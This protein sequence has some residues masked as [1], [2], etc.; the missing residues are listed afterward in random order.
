MT[1]SRGRAGTTLAIFMGLALGLSA[2]AKGQDGAA[3]ADPVAPPAPDAAPAPLDPRIEELRR[4]VQALR[5]EVEA[6]GEEKDKK[7]KLTG[8]QFQLRGGWFNLAHNHRTDILS[9]DDHQHG[10][11]VGIGLVVPIMP[12]LGP[13][14]LL[15]NLAIE[16]RQVA[17]STV[18]RSVLTN[19]SGTLSY[20]NIVACPMVRFKLSETIRP[21]VLA[22]LNM[23]VATPPTDAVTYLDLGVT[24]GLG[25]DFKVHERVSVGFDYRYS[26]F[27][28]SDQENEDYG[29]L[30]GYVG[31]NF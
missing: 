27:G 15:A 1:G 9:G 18:Y 24:I 20:L 14:D 13:I 25:L 2:T 17:Y 29:L 7:G 10:W 31:F 3:P 26:W 30:S 23:Q 28:V 16:Y 6:K 12:D 4:E 22:G 21:F 8:W 11:S 19:E 5:A